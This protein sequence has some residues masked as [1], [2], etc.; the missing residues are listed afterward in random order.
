ML[1]PVSAAAAAMNAKSLYAFTLFGK[2]QVNEYEPDL[3]DA[4]HM[5]DRP[6]KHLLRD[7]C[8]VARE[9]I[10]MCFHFFL[11]HGHKLV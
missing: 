11:R 7:S 8:I 2:T 4:R 10:K 9:S 6:V 5:S 3:A 1:A